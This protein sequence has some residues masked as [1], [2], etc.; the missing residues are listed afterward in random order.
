MESSSR[1]L[2]FCGYKAGL[3]GF[4]LV[5]TAEA[6][7]GNSSELRFCFE[8]PQC[9]LFDRICTADDYEVRRYTSVKWV[10]TEETS[11]IMELAAMRA[12]RR[13]YDYITGAN[14]NGQKIE[15]TAP[16]IVKMPAGKRFWEMGVYRMSFLLPAEHQKKPPKPTDEKVFIDEMPEMKV[17]VKSYGGWLSTTSDRNNAKELS[18]TLDLFNAEYRKDFYYGAGYNRMDLPGY[19]TQPLVQQPDNYPDPNPLEG[20]SAS[21]EIKTEPDSRPGSEEYCPICG[22]KVSGYHY[23]LLTCESCKGFFK[24]SVQNNKHYTCAEQQRCPMDLS[25]RKRCPFCRFQKCLAVGMKREA[26]RADRMR[27]GRNKFGPL[28]R[29]DRQMKQQKVYHQAN[30]APYRIKTETT[31]AHRPTAPNDHHLMSSHTSTPLSSDAFHYPPIYPPGL[32]QSGAPMRLDCTVNTERVLTPP[33]LPYTGLYHRTFSGYFQEKGE[34]PFSYS[35]VPPHYPLHPTLN[36]SFTTI[37]TPASSP[38][39]TSST[40]PLTQALP[41][42]SVNPPSGTLTPSFLSQL[43]EGEQDESQLCAK[44]LV[45]LQREQANRGKH[46]R[47]NT[48]SIMCKMADQTLFG[49]VE[50]ARNSTLFKELKV[51]DQMVLLQSCW[52]EL[53]VLDHLCRQVTYGN[54]GCIYLVTGQQIEVSTIISQAG[55]TLSSLVS[56]TQ[57]LVSKLK[58]LQLDRHE[59]VCLKYLVLFNPDVKSVQSRRQVEQTQE[60]VNRAL[61]E[62]TQQSHPGHSDKFGQLLL[63]LPEID[64]AEP[65]KSSQERN[66]CN[67]IG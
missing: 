29:R 52:S 62:H 54:E 10:S 57:D 39:S 48:F 19:Q 2:V 13:L 5:L 17:Y 58:A 66:N 6:R 26:V 30:T 27:G 61:M 37:S 7:V 53:L 67:Y 55:V 23:G 51:E 8:T 33:P 59:F 41:Q 50:W 65:I 44:V 40:T 63:R 18:D 49:L 46:D 32:G 31:Q 28:Y 35:T 15:M 11:F 4:L 20:S 42:T 36:N 38:C 43:L 21:Q 45:S 9:L 56:R 34:T 16:V 12:F 64:Q 1:D 25:Q 60:R 3:V 14:K 22:D 24:R 47:L